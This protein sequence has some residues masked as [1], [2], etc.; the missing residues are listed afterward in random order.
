MEG[1]IPTRCPRRISPRLS[2]R[3]T[4]FF[5]ALQNAARAVTTAVAVAAPA[6]AAAVAPAI[7]EEEEEGGEEAEK[8]GMGGGTGRGTRSSIL[9]P[10]H[11]TTRC[12]SCSLRVPPACP[13]AWSTEPG[14]RV[15]LAFVFRA[16]GSWLDTLP[17]PALPRP[18]ATGDA[19]VVAL[20]S[21]RVVGRGCGR[22]LI[23]WHIE[24]KLSSRAPFWHA[25]LPPPFGVVRHFSPAKVL[26][27]RTL[28]SV[29]LVGTFLLV[30]QTSGRSRPAV[31]DLDPNPPV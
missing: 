19:G 25:S 27:A 1:S 10:P 8:C 31:D 15:V 4:S 21:A 11:S 24:K 7:A 13:S 29:R 22:C 16:K 5:S 26:S 23:E 20:L 12:S 17:T 18:P 6:A 30:C 28:S 14:V 9:S 3:S 2:Y